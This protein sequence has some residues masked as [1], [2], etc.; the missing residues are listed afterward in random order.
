MTII[1]DSK[2]ENNSILSSDICIIG[3]GMS[4]Q[5]L[6]SKL[7]NRKIT[8]VESG[9]LHF[10]ED[11]QKLNQFEQVGINFRKNYQNR[12]RQL[13]GSGNL[14]ANQLMI[15]KEE[16]IKN[17][18]W[19]TKDFSWPFSFEELKNLYEDVIKNIYKNNFK[20][21]NIFDPKK[22]IKKENFLE[23]EFIKS[24]VFE[25]NQHFW[26]SRVEKFNL[27]SNFTKEILHSKNL[28]FLESFTA[29]DLYINENSKVVESIKIQSK[30]KTCKI[31]SNL[32]VLA[33]GAVENA[34]ILLNN[35]KNIKLLENENIG[36]YFMDHPRI[37]LGTIK[38]KKKLPLSILFGIKYKN[39]DI[40]KSISLSKKFRLDNNILDGYAFIDP[41]YTDN[42]ELI[43]ENFLS[44]FKKL[45]KLNG[46]PKI[47]LKNLSIKEIIEQIYLKLSPQISNST[48]NVLLRNFFERKNYYFSF[49]EMCINYQSEQFPNCESKIYLSDKKDHF[50]Q[51]LA[52]IDWKLNEIDYR[53]H[54]IFVKNLKDKFNSHNFLNFNENK[55]KK[56]TDASHHSGTTRMSLDKSDGVVDKNCKV[57]DINNLYISGSSV[58]RSSGSINPGLTNMA[59]SN[60]LGNY[61]QNLKL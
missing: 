8:M 5:I 49:D 52:I 14:W 42:D 59:I 41:K 23:N 53:T 18:D 43:F 24:E 31:K 15:F 16:D 22:S 47:N 35:Q 44:E 7:K 37:T 48:I 32:F 2:I 25:F 45:I 61:I 60:R 11:I 34:R 12:I 13:G 17:R 54:A 6:T 33:C 4:A 36:K 3:S 19:V 57:H 20:F 50:D 39:Y 46:F 51:N 58:F 28:N 30:N 38:S 26:P 55:N 9:K 10:D 40:R 27:K 29:T 56:I 21:S 1:N